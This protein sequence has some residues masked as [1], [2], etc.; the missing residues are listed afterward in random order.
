MD[1]DNRSRN[2]ILFRDNFLEE[3]FQGFPGETAEIRKQFFILEEI[4]TKDFGYAEDKMPVG[5]GL[6][7]F[8]TKPLAKFHHLFLVA[9]WTKMP[10]LA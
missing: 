7:H 1:S 6:E 5:C 2:L 3:F 8:L 4:P 10:S 9:G